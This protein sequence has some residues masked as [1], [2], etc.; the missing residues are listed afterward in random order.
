MEKRLICHRLFI[1]FTVLS[2]VQSATAQSDFWE[3]CGHSIAGCIMSVVQNPSGDLFA[4]VKEQAVFRSTN[5]G[6]SWFEFKTGLPNSYLTQ[7]AITSA[8]HLFVGTYDQGVYWSTDNGETW[9]SINTGL[10]DLHI[11]AVLVD[12]SDRVYVSTCDGINRLRDNAMSW[13]KIY[14]TD[15]DTR[16][17]CLAYGWNGKLVAGTKDDR[18]LQSSDKGEHWA[19]LS[20]RQHEQ[21]ISVVLAA[22][23]RLFAYKM[24]A[25]WGDGDGPVY[26]WLRSDDMGLTWHLVESI[27]MLWPTPQNYLFGT[28][29]FEIGG[30]LLRSHDNGDTWTKLTVDSVDSLPPEVFYC[31]ADSNGDIL[32]FST[33]PISNETRNGGVFRSSDHGDHWTQIHTS[34]RQAPVYNLIG[35]ASGDLFASTDRGIFLST[36]KGEK[37]HRVA[38]GR[39][40]N[41]QYNAPSCYPVHLL[42]ASAAGFL[43]AAI[44]ND[45]VY[46]STDNGLNWLRLQHPLIDSCRFT[47]IANGPQGSVYLSGMNRSDSPILLRSTDNGESWMLRNSGLENVEVYALAV[48]PSNSIF[49]GTSKGAIYRSL[50]NG[51]TWLPKTTG[52][53]LYVVLN[54]SINKNGHIFAAFGDSGI[55]RS[56]D[57]GE[58][59]NQINNG[60][61]SKEVRSIVFNSHSHLFAAL[62]DGNIFRSVDDG[63]TWAFYASFAEIWEPERN[64]IA[65]IVHPDGRLFIG[66]NGLQQFGVFRSKE[67]TLTN[68]ERLSNSAVPIQFKLLQNYPNPFNPTTHIKYA[69]A[70]AEKVRLEVYNA[71]GQRMVLLVDKQQKAGE[72]EIFFRGDGLASGLYFYRLQAGDFFLQKKMLLLR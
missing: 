15:E 6:A 32:A 45:G 65:L 58:S 28:R 23:G 30:E 34:I 40:S 42:S 10:T 35:T 12:S 8:G 60:L 67:S 47:A 70:R 61:S 17:Q 20:N 16:V 39:R 66:F 72:H 49:A 71:L 31:F 21:T 55:W 68:I 52:L 53:S 57:N 29:F 11:A 19:V 13:E 54:F 56:T 37:W 44:D 59:W 7:M 36:D 14:S 3:P 38:F 2:I 64:S 25:A 24:I 9:S 43:F 22:S 62:N 48:H 1:A 4:A 46:R 41:Y 63:D 27:L 69:L 50:D 18:L 5:G 33:R 26:G 51:E